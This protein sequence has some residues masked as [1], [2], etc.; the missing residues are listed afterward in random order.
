MPESGILYT[1]HAE[2]IPLA[3]GVASLWSFETRSWERGRPKISCN[4]D[5]SYEYWLE[6]SDPLLNTILPGTG[7]SL[8][9]NFGDLWAAGR[10]LATCELLPRVCVVGPVTQSRV[11]RVGRVVHAAGAGFP[12]ALTPN[13]FG[14]PASDLVDRIVPL[15]DLWPREDVESLLM[16]PPMNLGCYVSALARELAAHTLR[17]I[18]T[19][20]VGQRAP[21][22]ISRHPR[23]L[24]I[25]DLALKHGLSRQ[26][27]ARRFSAATGLTPK[28]F[29]RLSRFQALV[30]AL[31]SSDVSQWASIST[32][33]GFYDQAHMIN[34]FRALAGSPPTVFFRPHGG[35]IDPG[36]IQLRGRPSEWVHCTEP[37]N[38]PRDPSVVRE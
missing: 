2:L 12:S 13:V 3:P 14:L 10:S 21:L 19:D 31:L 22:F 35:S 38:D 9:V 36:S 32:A 4:L 6:R 8:V 11:L 15:Q 5:S 25:E 27:F 26:H 16:F 37:I 1:E 33:T 17:S 28:L 20:I 24:S 18:R 30:Q 29:A 7:I 23:N 34:E